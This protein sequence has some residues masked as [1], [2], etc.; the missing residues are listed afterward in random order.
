LRLLVKLF[1]FLSRRTG[2]K[3]NHQILKRLFYSKG[4]KAPV[5]TSRLAHAQKVDKAR[6]LVVVGTVVDDTRFL[7]L[8]KIKVAALHVRRISGT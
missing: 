6:V 1:R 2:A 7:D 5:S 3:F 8:P 4:N